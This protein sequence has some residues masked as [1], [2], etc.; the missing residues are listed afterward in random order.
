[1]IKCEHSLPGQYVQW[2]NS[3]GRMVYLPFSMAYCLSGLMIR[4]FSVSAIAGDVIVKGIVP[5]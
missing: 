1:M 4:P 5:F 3:H 2:R